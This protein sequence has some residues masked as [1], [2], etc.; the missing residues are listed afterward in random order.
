M[1]RRT[2]AVVKAKRA[3]RHMTPRHIIKTRITA[4]IIQ[5]FAEKA[6]FV[7]FG[8]V[9]QRDDE[10]RLVRGHTVSATHLDD[11]YCVGS[12]RGYDAIIVLRNDVITKRNRQ[13]QRC[14]WLICSV[15]LRTKM[16]I[17]HMYIGHRNRDEAFGASFELLHPLDLGIYATYP[18]VFL[19]D[20]TIYGRATDSIMI[21]QTITPDVANVIAQHFRG[22]SIEIEENTIYLYIESQY[23][24]EAILEKM[25]SNVL[26]L[27]EAIDTAFTPTE[28]EA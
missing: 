4:R 5:K 1:S 12:L 3:L 8:H 22:A 28:A 14:H 19:S 23:P 26:W 6:G 10:H 20:Y 17:P 24:D 13:Q 21:E 9:S 27:A 16:T 18:A 7:Y 2:R 25:L 11:H 15:D